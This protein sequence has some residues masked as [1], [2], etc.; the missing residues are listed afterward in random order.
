MPVDTFYGADCEFRIGHM[1]DKDTDPT[2]WHKLQF[3]TMTQGQQRDRKARP[4]LGAGRHNALDPVKPIPGFFRTSSDLVV[5]AD[6]RQLPR[7]LRDLLGAPATTGPVGGLYTHVWNSGVTTPQYAAIQLRT[8]ADQVRVWRGLTLGALAISGTGEQVQ[9]YD[10]QLSLRGLTRERPADW[11]AGAAEALPVESPMSRAV[12]R[13]DGAAAT[14]TLNANWSWDRQL[15]EDVFL[16][17]TANL[18]GLRPDGGVLTGSARF[19]A[20][21]EAFDDIEEADTVFAPDIQ[22]LGVNAGHTIK[23]EHPHAQFA[24]APLEIPGP[25]LIERTYSWSGHQDATTPGARITI[26]NDVASYAV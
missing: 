24:A 3:M 4:K 25:G 20:V 9:D 16:S 1:A 23:F 7:L 17:T 14:N 13:I 18:S 6:S 15:T 10:V 2:A 19:R 12:F 26:V 21:A 5:D 22:M 11:L 8:A